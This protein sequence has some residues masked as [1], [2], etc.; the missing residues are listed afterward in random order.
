M[1][2]SEPTQLVVSPNASLSWHHARNFLFGVS[3]VAFGVAGWF[4]W[5]AGAWPALIF[6][7]LYLGGLGA[8]LV[9]S[10]RRNDYREVLV[11]DQDRIDIKTGFIGRKTIIR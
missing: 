11:F 2:I 4:T 9:V 5:L 6:A 10:L 3:M 7:A 1:E 8:A